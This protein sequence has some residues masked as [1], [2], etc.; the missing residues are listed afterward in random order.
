MDFPFPQRIA[1]HGCGAK[2]RVIGKE[3]YEMHEGVASVAWAR[4]GKCR[5]TFVRFL[6][7]KKAAAR[8]MEMWLG[9]HRK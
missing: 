9:L 8:A 1:C 6:G 4:C 5:H 3:V 2:R 7:E